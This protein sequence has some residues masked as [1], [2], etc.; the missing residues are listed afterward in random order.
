MKEKYQHD[1]RMNT[2]ECDQNKIA[3]V[4]GMVQEM[5]EAARWQMSIQKP[6]YSD[7]QREGKALMLSR[8]DLEVY[9]PLHIDELVTVSSWPCESNRAIF[10]RCY[11]MQVGERK[12]AEIS[13]QWALVDMD[14]RKVLKTDEVDFSNYYM[15]EYKELHKGKFKIPKD[16]VLEEAGRYRVGYSDLDSNGHMNNTYYL[17][18]LCDYI[19]ELAAGGY[20]VKSV[21]IHYNKEAPVGEIITIFRLNER[22]GKYIFRTVKSDGEINVE[23]EIAVRRI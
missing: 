13:S 20:M 1:C 16:A 6:S 9:E 7:L 19:P 23:A 3:K 12:I 4:S 18:V 22:D 11:D 5:Q 8:L 2:Y 10:F 15:G 17:D 21:R 14:T